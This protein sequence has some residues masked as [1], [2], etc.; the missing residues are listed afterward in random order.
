M[1]T[2]KLKSLI[3]NGMKK[4][5][6]HSVLVTLIS[7]SRNRLITKEKME[8]YYNGKIQHH[9]DPTVDMLKISVNDD[10]EDL[11]QKLRIGEDYK[12]S[13]WSYYLPKLTKKELRLVELRDEVHLKTYSSYGLPKQDL[14]ID[15]KEM[16]RS[17][18]K[19]KF[20]MSNCFRWSLKIENYVPAE[21]VF[22][23][24]ESSQSKVELCRP[25]SKCNGDS[26]L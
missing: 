23:K 21:S 11:L 2:D 24:T 6:I 25:C 1:H 5:K 12:E 16:K 8:D 7:Q 4:Y 18:S 15:E 14:D 19:S 10:L 26:K 20:L 22:S 9:R 13:V 3:L 17:E